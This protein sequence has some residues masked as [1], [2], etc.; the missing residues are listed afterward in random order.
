MKINFVMSGLT[1]GERLAQDT[2]G[3]SCPPLPSA[4]LCER[5]IVFD[6]SEH[7]MYEAVVA[8]LMQMPGVGSFT[9][10]APQSLEQF[11]LI[12]NTFRSFKARQTI[13]RAVQSSAHVLEHYERLVMGVVLPELKAWLSITGEAEGSQSFY[14]QCPPSLRLQHGASPEF[15]RVHR[16][17]EY[18]HQPGEL[19]FWMPL[20]SGTPTL[21][22]ES[23]PDAGDFHALQVEYGA[24]ACFHGALCRHFAPPNASESLRASLD[25]RVGIGQYF[26]PGWTLQG[27]KAQHT[28]K[29]V[30]SVKVPTPASGSE[31]RPRT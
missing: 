23:S 15:G 11:A 4:L 6:T 28:W 9:P 2:A 26:D 29:E 3:P 30:P 31:I 22:V 25:F 17:R 27:I 12:I 14:Y 18:G 5:T 1:K 20:T 13:Y 10:S 8:L 19:N 16:D 21:H 24:I 7:K